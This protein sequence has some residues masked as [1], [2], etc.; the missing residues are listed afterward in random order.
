MVNNAPRQMKV[1]IRN[2]ESD[3]A[4]MVAD[5]SA[6]PPLPPVVKPSHAPSEH[7]G[8]PCP[9]FRDEADDNEDWITFDKPI[10]YI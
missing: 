5:I 2:P 3:K 8:M 9:I 7:T 10:T 1:T 4:K 6:D